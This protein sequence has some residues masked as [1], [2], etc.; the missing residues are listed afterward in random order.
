MQQKKGTKYFSLK[1]IIKIKIRLY[2]FYKK[3]NCDQKMLHTYFGDKSIFGKTFLV[4]TFLEIHLK[5][6]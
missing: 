3:I 4:K 6:K 2:R 5:K 1:K